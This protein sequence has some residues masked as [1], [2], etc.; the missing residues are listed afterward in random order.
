VKAVKPDKTEQ[1]AVALIE[2]KILERVNKAISQNNES[3][4][5]VTIFFGIL[6]VTTG[7]V[8]YTNAGHNPPYIRRK[9]GLLQRLDDRHGPVI[10]ATS[11]TRYKEA[12]EMLSSGDLLFIYTDGVTEA[13]NSHQA[14]FT[15][16]RLKARLNKLQNQNAKSAV[17]DVV[18]AA[19]EFDD[20]EQTDD[21][22]V[23]ALH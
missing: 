23:L 3:A 9:D 16:E 1:N 12:T 17:E 8:V 22:T 11:D 2:A 14:L 18:A 19:K 4:M 21:I 6:D 13:M 20:V 5:F 15:E 7:E 10:G